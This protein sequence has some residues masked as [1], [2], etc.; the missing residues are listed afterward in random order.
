MVNDI[1]KKLKKIRTQKGIT[2]RELG[3]AVGMS[4]G[5]LSQLERGKSSIAI[6][7]LM[8]IADYLGVNMR[9]FITEQ[10]S[11]NSPVLR[12]YENEIMYV[13][14]ELCVEYK[15]SSEIHDKMMLPKMT[16]LM[17]GFSTEAAHNHS[18]EEFIYILEGV[19]T[20]GIDG[21][22]YT[23]YP[24]DTAQYGA[25][26]EH[27]WENNTNRM[28]KLLVISTPNPFNQKNG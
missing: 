5:Y 7:H 16:V 18:G 1:G 19:M 8:K 2:L 14:N 25:S 6:N 13:E 9:Y 15:V 26:K 23:M 10:F 3:D 24:G 17:P 12:S 28:V 21:K 4:A 20:F 22:E 11:N 27:K